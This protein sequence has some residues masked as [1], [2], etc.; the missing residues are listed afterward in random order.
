MKSSK[1]LS[2]LALAVITFSLSVEAA[3]NVTGKRTRPL[4]GVQRWDMFSGKGSTQE[5]QL[6]YL[7]GGPGFLKDSQ[8]HDRLPF[9]CRR[10]KDVDWVG[11]PADAGPVR[12]NH[13][14]SQQLLQEFD[15][16]R[17]SSN[18]P[19]RAKGDPARQCK[20]CRYLIRDGRRT[21]T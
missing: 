20:R 5:K 13:P 21:L 8:W 3:E 17:K 15:A 11:H 9:F 7:P 4:L 18:N 2:L 6:G 12:F 10:T 1:R 16:A 14:F 19:D